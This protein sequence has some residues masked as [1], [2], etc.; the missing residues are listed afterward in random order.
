MSLIAVES[1]T[2]GSVAT[3]NITSVDDNGIHTTCLNESNI[4]IDEWAHDVEPE[5]ILAWAAETA[6]ALA[7]AIADIYVGKF[8]SS[9]SDAAAEVSDT[10]EKVSAG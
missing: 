9:I 2:G 6:A 7:L 4:R 3:L 5:E 1:C 10:L 8:Q